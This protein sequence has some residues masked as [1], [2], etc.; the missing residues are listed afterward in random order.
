MT[1]PGQPCR[2]TERAAPNRQLPTASWHEALARRHVLAKDTHG[3]TI[4]LAPPI[5][6]SEEQLDAGLDA[7]AAALAELAARPR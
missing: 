6:I 1:P 5:V 4:R 7:L 2:R 3:S